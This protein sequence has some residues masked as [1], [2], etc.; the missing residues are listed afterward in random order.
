M[1]NGRTRWQ[2]LCSAEFVGR[3]VSKGS[4]GTRRY[5]SCAVARAWIS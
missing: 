5:E 1:R 2:G 3:F 4:V